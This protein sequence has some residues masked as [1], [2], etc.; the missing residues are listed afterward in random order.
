MPRKAI[1]LIAVAALLSGCSRD[2]SSN[3]YTQSSA[4]GK[5]LKGTIIS[6]RTV[7]IKEHDKLQ[8][9]TTG[10]LA[11]GA[12]GAAGGSAI[13]NGT[14]GIAAAIGGA[15]IG[16]VGGAYVQDALGTNEGIEYI[17]QID[18]G[19]VDKGDA[20]MAGTGKKIKENSS[21]GIVQDDVAT[22]VNTNMKTDMIS[23]VEKA[24]P[25]LVTGSRVFVIYSN[26][27][28]RLTPIPANV[29]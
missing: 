2:M 25:A 11:G 17:V 15:I 29:Q 4:A 16:A 18:S 7:T 20:A 27:R 24:D 10:G 8:D 3:T 23:V 6:T 1:V 9:N 28:P 14:G 12:L 19:Y 22:S 5:V 13:G 21:G 26:D